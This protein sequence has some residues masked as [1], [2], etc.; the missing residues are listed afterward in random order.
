MRSFLGNRTPVVRN[1]WRH[2]AACALICE[3][4]SAIY[5]FSPD[6]A[7][8]A[9][10]MHDIGRLGMI[11]QYSKEITPVLLAEY[12][13]MA[14]VLRAEREALQVDHARAGAWL[15]KNWALPST[16]WDICEHHHGV[17]QPK[18]SELLQLVKVACGIADALGYAAVRCRHQAGYEETIQ[19][20]AP[21]LVRPQ[22]SAARAGTPLECGSPH[23]RLRALGRMRK[24]D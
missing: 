6:R 16:F 20:L 18:D 8:T 4:L 2:S 10:I 3:E 15:V 19:A 24:K 12:E 17:P 5:D 14:A 11:K 23:E 22:R 1:C 9:G 21:R 13:D 7:Y